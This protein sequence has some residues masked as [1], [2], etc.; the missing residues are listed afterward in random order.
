MSCP[1]LPARALFSGQITADWVRIP[2]C[3]VWRGLREEKRGPHIQSARREVEI[4]RDEDDGMMD[5][6]LSRD[7]CPF[8]H[9]LLKSINR[10]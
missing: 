7:D 3:V 9:L 10:K 5:R 2:R 6:P 8:T 1:G 4:D